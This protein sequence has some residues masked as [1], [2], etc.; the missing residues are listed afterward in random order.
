ME[1]QPSSELLAILEA[2]LGDMT[3]NIIFC[4]E[5]KKKAILKMQLKND[6]YQ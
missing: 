5:V 6:H 1:P 4:H 3:S 2:M